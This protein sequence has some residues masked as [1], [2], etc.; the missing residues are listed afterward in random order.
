MAH[1]NGVFVGFWY[2]MYFIIKCDIKLFQKSCVIQQQHL[3][4]ERPIVLLCICC[5]IYVYILF[6]GF[7]NWIIGQIQ[8]ISLAVYMYILKP[9]IIRLFSKLYGRAWF[10]YEFIMCWGLRV[11]QPFCI[12]FQTI[13]YYRNMDYIIKYIECI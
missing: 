4:L 8:F 10:I 5:I 7:C 13:I 11:S 6:Y 9:I 1:N 12:H 3:V 2:L